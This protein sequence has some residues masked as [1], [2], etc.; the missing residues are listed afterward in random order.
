MELTFLIPLSNFSYRWDNLHLGDILSS[1]YLS[2]YSIFIPSYIIPSGFSWPNIPC[3][4]SLNVWGFVFTHNH[5]HWNHLSLN[6][7]QFL[8]ILF[9]VQW[10]NVWNKVCPT[11]NIT[12]QVLCM[13]WKRY[14]IK[15]HLPFCS[16]STPLIHILF[17]IGS[18][19]EP[20]LQCTFK[21]VSY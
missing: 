4:F 17:A 11:K 3:S 19:L 14:I 18:Y 9:K 7:S 10:Q 5:S 21:S 16:H 6:L 15:L 8:W 1:I 20:F 13:F 2:F 12:E